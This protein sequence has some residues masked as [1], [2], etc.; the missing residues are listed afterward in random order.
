MIL[1]V[2]QVPIRPDQ[3]DEWLS[4]IQRYTEAVRQEPSNPTFECHESIETPNQFMIVEGFASREAGDEHVKTD[5]F[6]DFMA[7]FPKVLA[8]PPKIINTEV[9]GWS[10]MSELG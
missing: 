6:K 10:E 8:G 5:H 4:G 2:L 9:E 3:R 7:W 1:I